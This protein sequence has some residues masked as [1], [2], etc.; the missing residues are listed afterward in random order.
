M[1]APEAAL[2]PIG[3]I[4]LFLTMLSSFKLL[5]THNGRIIVHGQPLNLL[6]HIH[7]QALALGMV[8]TTIVIVWP[9]P[10]DELS[11]VRATCVT[12]E[13]K[14]SSLPEGVAHTRHRYMELMGTYHL[15]ECA[16][17]FSFEMRHRFLYKR[18]CP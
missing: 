13:S 12:R 15:L 7:T 6:S 1:G 4:L 5:R 17:F 10:L 8:V 9:G 16:W 11:Y 2:K 14:A 3:A 18:V